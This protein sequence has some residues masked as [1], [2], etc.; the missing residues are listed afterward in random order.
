MNESLNSLE[1]IEAY[2][3]SVS[4]EMAEELPS[5]LLASIMEEDNCILTA[6]IIENGGELLISPE[7]VY[8]AMT[9]MRHIVAA[10]IASKEEII[11]AEP[12]LVPL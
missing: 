7:S 6:A 5:Q 2:A 1:M 12:G 8:P 11:H 3:E 4:A 10:V 9:R